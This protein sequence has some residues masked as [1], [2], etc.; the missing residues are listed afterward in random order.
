MIGC[1]AEAQSEVI[2]VDR[3]ELQDAAWFDRELVRRAL[4]GDHAELIVPPPFAIAHHLMRAWVAG[5]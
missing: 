1:I 3:T 5:D 2:T 4:A